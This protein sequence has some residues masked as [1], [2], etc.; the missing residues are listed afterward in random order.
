LYCGRHT[1]FDIS[2]TEK[3]YIDSILKKIDPEKTKS[4]FRVVTFDNFY[5]LFN[6]NEKALIERIITIDPLEYG[7][8]GK[9]FG[10][11]DVPNDL[12]EIVDQKYHHKDEIKTVDIQ[13]LPKQPYLAYQKLNESLY[14]EKVGNLLVLSGYRSSAYQA[15]V[16]L[17]Y[18]K[19]YKFDLHKTVRRAAIPGYSEH[20]FPKQQ[21]IDFMT[22]NGSP[23][24]DNPE[25]FENTD[26]YKWLEKNAKKFGFYLTNPRNNKLG[27]MYEPWHWAYIAD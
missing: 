22:E 10:I 21:A 5:K 8:K 4:E 3:K 24:E 26:E 9:Y 6:K 19:F 20:G 16:F 12:V 18:L 23:T 17:W 1:K 7:F 14:K 25:D 15:F 11:Q 27:T 2:S 13:Y